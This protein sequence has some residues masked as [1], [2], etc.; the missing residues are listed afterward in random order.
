MGDIVAVSKQSVHQTWLLARAVLHESRY[1]ANNRDEGG[2]SALMWPMVATATAI[3]C[4]PV[5]VIGHNLGGFLAVQAVLSTLVVVSI[6]GQVKERTIS[7]F[8]S[9]MPFPQCLAKRVVTWAII[10]GSAIPATIFPLFAAITTM[11]V[12]LGLCDTIG[13]IISSILV[14]WWPACLSGLLAPASIWVPCN[15][16]KSLVTEASIQISATK[17]T[18]VIGKTILDILF[19]DAK[20]AATMLAPAV[21]AIAVILGGFSV[22]NSDPVL[23]FF[24]LYVLTGLLPFFVAS[25]VSNAGNRLLPGFNILPRFSR[26]LLGAKQAISGLLFL[27]ILVTSTVMLSTRTSDPGRFLLLATSLPLIGWFSCSITILALDAI[28]HV[29]R[30][31]RHFLVLIF[32][33]NIFGS[34]FWN[35]SMIGIAGEAMTTA[36]MII[37]G[38]A[39]IA[40]QELLK[41]LVYRCTG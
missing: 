11:I 14:S 2:G 29:V 41:K 1:W 19:R 8:L 27:S 25:A 28:S 38:L 15:P 37:L 24:W 23:A 32:V 21:L 7:S 9:S 35:L 12:P 31:G 5:L 30:V 34:M 33:V 10:I 18:L 22:N 16:S 4:L 40:G 3:A 36:I 17:S 39:G 6:A 20:H 13:I 26:V